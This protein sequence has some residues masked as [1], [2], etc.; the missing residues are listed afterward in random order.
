M[1]LVRVFFNPLDARARQEFT[2]EPGTQIIEFLQA[3]FPAGFGAPVRVF[4]GRDEV[5]PDDWDQVIA[6]DLPL[7]V[8]VLPAGL[9]W[10][11]VGKILIQAVVAAAIGY[12]INLIF[13]P[14]EPGL[15]DRGDESPVY[16]IGATRNQARLGSP[17]PAH[18]GTPIF[19]PD[20][21]SV[22]YVFNVEASN[23]QFVDELLCL[24]HGK[25]VIHD[26]KIGNM[27]IY[28]LRAGA[29]KYWQF[30]SSQHLMTLGT[31]EGLINADV[32]GSD[33]PTPFYENMYTSPE[34]TD[35][36]FEDGQSEEVS[37]QS[38]DGDAV[39]ETV[40]G[41]GNRIPGRIINITRSLIEDPLDTSK[42]LLRKGDKLN[43]R[44]TTSNNVEF[45]IGSVVD[46]ATVSIFQSLDDPNPIVDESP[47]P[48]TTEF[49]L[50]VLLDNFVAGPYRA[51]RDG[52]SISEAF[53]D[54]LFPQGLYHRDGTDGTIKNK[55]INYGF[56]F[57]KI[58]ADGSADGSP[59]Y[60]EREIRAKQM[61][62]YRLSISS[63]ALTEGAY[64]VTVERLDE[65][66][67]QRNVETCQW[68]GLR[69]AVVHDTTATVY[70]DVTLLAIRM[71]A[72]AGL[73]SAA[74]ERVR[75][76]ATRILEDETSN[77]ANPI[78]V[79]KDI[80]TNSTYGLGGA[81]SGMDVTWLDDL[82][83][84]W[85]GPT[86]PRF[87]GSF[88]SRSTG[89][90]AMD[91]VAALNGSKVVHDGG[92]LTVIP[93]HIQDVRSAVFSTANMVTDSLSVLYTFNTDGDYDGM[94]V[95]YRD[96]LNF[97]V[98]YAYYPDNP[99]NPETYT[100]FGCTDETYA[101]QFARYL[102]NVRGRRRKLVTLQ[103]ELE[104]LIPRFGDRI[105]VSH[106]VPAWGQ[107]GVFLEQIDA[108]SWYVDQDL[109][110]TSDN[111]MVI[112]TELGTGSE[113][114]TVTEGA[115]PNIVVFDSAPSETIA[116]AAD[117]EPTNYI[118]GTAGALIKDF[119]VTRVTPKTDT[120]IEVQGQTYDELIYEGAP[121]H[122]RNEFVLP[123]ASYGYGLTLLAPNVWLANENTSYA[124]ED[125]IASD[126]EDQPLQMLANA[127]VL[128]DNAGLLPNPC[129][130]EYA[131]SFEGANP[132][133]YRGT[134]FGSTMLFTVSALIGPPEGDNEMFSTVIFVGRSSGN[135]LSLGFP[136]SGDKKRLRILLANGGFSHEI[137]MDDFY[138][139]GE[140]FVLSAALEPVGKYL[141]V[142]KNW[143]LIISESVSGW[144]LAGTSD[145][146]YHFAL[147]S[148]YASVS[149][150]AIWPNVISDGDAEQL[151]DFWLAQV[152]AGG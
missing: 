63:G 51:Q 4:S 18:Y 100:L 118:F 148:A 87:N 130:T 135:Y 72:T 26:I 6:E 54:L 41:E 98:A 30:D 97:D 152:A 146:R 17:I 91:S 106:T 57:Q 94:Q 74:R 59:V 33:N 95:E 92:L 29:V 132:Q 79:I 121:P 111:V 103:T 131:A 83:A 119:M 104:G 5:R 1:S 141:Y 27:S 14:K 48:G 85:G 122:M 129:S 45:I 101:S 134:D 117:R 75:V 143:D 80:W 9:T 112:R 99:A 2:V 31:I 105:G 15:I 46:G 110:W 7:T 32:A 8:L 12:V 149:H 145:P 66:G 23:D 61:A 11:A 137:W 10:A 115:T 102:W 127:T 3:E 73:G 16:S 147:N 44:N 21:A 126:V 88:D 82:E 52:D 81:L 93:D 67:D 76:R 133:G 22:P 64:E 47:L 125:P 124:D 120:V 139:N 142:W 36:T 78:T 151:R 77:S 138:T 19:P 35:F 28:D 53:V 25:F 42:L 40:D 123:C 58:L 65:F 50:N 84:D 108:T 89:Y 70:G 68:V 116:T 114:Y 128:V 56:T 34:I 49:E 90:E 96:P 24:G 113:L 71:K 136:D 86:G 43:L 39:A 107:S 13:A 150:M 109:D 140:A 62:P 60:F 69:G 55:T 38:I 20:F 37:W 144:A